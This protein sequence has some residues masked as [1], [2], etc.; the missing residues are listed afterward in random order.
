MSKSR[1]LR[2]KRKKECKG[3]IF[4]LLILN[5]ELY[6]FPGALSFILP[7]LLFS[8]KEEKLERYGRK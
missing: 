2:M 4:I 5:F 7:S 3:M 8:G 6:L 1:R